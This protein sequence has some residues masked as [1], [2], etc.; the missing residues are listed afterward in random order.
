MSSSIANPSGANAYVFLCS[1]GN[2]GGTVGIAWLGGTCDSSGY[3][4]SSV[5]EY[6]FNDATTAEVSHFNCYFTT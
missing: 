2:Q 4:R 6:F 5:N 3:G 1:Q